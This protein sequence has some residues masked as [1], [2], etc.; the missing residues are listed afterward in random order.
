MTKIIAAIL[1]LMLAVPAYA[2]QKPEPPKVPPRIAGHTGIPRPQATGTTTIAFGLNGHDGRAYYPLAEVE[3]RM[4]WMQANHLTIWRT[5]VGA[6]SFDILDK[7]VP[8]ARKYGIT[9]RPMLYPSTQAATYTIAKRYAN[10]I[11]IWEVGNEQDAPRDGAQ[12]R[13]NAMLPSVRGVEQAEAE[14]HAGLK[15][16]INIMSCNDEGASQCQGDP[17]G[18]VWFLDMAKASGWNFNYVSFHYYPRVHDVGHWMNKYLGQARHAATKF[19]VPVFFNEV[20]CGEIYDGDTAGGPT[21][22]TALTQALNEVVN[23]YSDVFAEVVVYEML[24]QPDMSGV[25]RFF[26]VCYVL[27]NC[28]PTA[29]TV[30]QFG[31]M[32]SGGTA[33]PV[34]PPEGGGGTPTPAPPYSGT[35]SGTF[36]GTVT[37]TPAPAK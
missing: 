28:K 3:Q 22:V 24:D 29:A 16:T 17:N 37:L 27:N 32:S 34:I 2:Q 35:V 6:T 26:G 23:K 7:V 9:V 13:I 31:E 18:D 19:G 1:L 10:D 33:P 36:T 11:K 20:N 14:L 25:E 30:A 12:D 8:L 4:Q 21:C 15:T 5:D